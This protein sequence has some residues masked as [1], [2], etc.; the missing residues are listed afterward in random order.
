MRYNSKGKHIRLTIIG[1]SIISLI[2]NYFWSNIP[3][4]SAPHELLNIVIIIKQ[5]RKPK[6]NY[7]NF[8]LFWLKNDIMRF[9]V[10][11]NDIKIMKLL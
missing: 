2:I 6:I 5:Q 11:M 8:F 7:F 1:F 9:Q 3:H 4:R 10:T